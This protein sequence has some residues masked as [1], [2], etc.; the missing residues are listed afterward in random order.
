MSKM[1]LIIEDEESI[2]NIIKAFLE[3]AGYTVVLAADGL[4]G[5]EQFRANKP[6]LVLLD[7][8][9]PKID[10]FAVCEILRKESHVPIIMLTALDDDDSQMKGFDALAD[11]YITK[12][13][14]LAV[15]YA[16]V[17]AMT[18]RFRGGAQSELLRRGDVTVNLHTRETFIAGSTMRLAPKEYDM[19][20]L[21]LENPN[22]IFTRDQLL[23][24]LWGYDFEGNERVVDNHIKKLRKALAESRCQI[25]TVRKSGYRMEV[26]V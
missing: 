12:P 9:L 22:R 25:H 18:G 20:L 14:S 5:I 15:L 2:Q 1:I 11:D 13:F 6:D 16:K 19:L 21:F 26:S 10:G 24:R 8:M 7:L 4:E 23:I 17:M 3:D